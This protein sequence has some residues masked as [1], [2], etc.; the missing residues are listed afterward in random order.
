MQPCAKQNQA[1]Y[2]IKS[3]FVR[4]SEQMRKISYVKNV[5]SLYGPQFNTAL[6]HRAVTN[7]VP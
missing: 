3:Y 6:L 5:K 2:V 7:L 4:K 1:I